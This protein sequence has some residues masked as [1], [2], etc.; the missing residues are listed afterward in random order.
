MIGKQSRAPVNKTSQGQEYHYSTP[1]PRFVNSCVV[2]SVSASL[3]VNSPLVFRLHGNAPDVVREVLL[4]R[5]WEEF[6]PQE[7]EEGDWNPRWR[8]SA[9]RGS[10]ENVLSWQRLNHHH[11]PGIISCKDLARNLRRMRGTY[12]PALYGFS[13]LAFIRT[14]LDYT[15]F[16]EEH[17]K[18]RYWICKPVDLSRG[19]GIFIFRDIKQLTY[20]STVIVQKYISN[21]FLISGYEPWLLEVN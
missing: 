5:G 9:F 11:K 20:D 1:L 21:P 14:K 4:E 16:L 19:R 10:D 18:N 6:D 3:R 17:A 15:R 7:R 2:F 8:S 13:P 12:G